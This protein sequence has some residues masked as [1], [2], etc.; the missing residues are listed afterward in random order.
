MLKKII[1]V[2]D[3]EITVR[4]LKTKEM[5]KLYETDDGIKLLVGLLAGLPAELDK[6]LRMSVDLTPEEFDNRFEGI[7]NYSLLESAFRE[8][9]IHFF[10]SLQQKVDTLIT[11]GKMMAEKFGVSLNKSAGLSK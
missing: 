1:V 5:V 7:S 10:A 11:T 4:E 8:V 6:V 3:Q 2:D 9:N